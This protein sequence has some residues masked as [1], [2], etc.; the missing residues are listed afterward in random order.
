M[1][2]IKVTLKHTKTTKNT[3][4]FG[5]DAEG[6]PVRSQ[7]IQREAIEGDPPAAIRITIEEAK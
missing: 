1:K 3:H 7:Y 4:V 5:D 6:A 2:P